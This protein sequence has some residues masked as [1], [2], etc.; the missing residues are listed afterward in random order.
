MRVGFVH[1]GCSK[2]LIDTEMAIGVFKD[3][4]Y[5]IVKNVKCTLQYINNIVNK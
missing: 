1:L 2:N 4:N 5:E 3:E